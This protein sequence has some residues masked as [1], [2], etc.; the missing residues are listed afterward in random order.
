M[1]ASPLLLSSR[2]LVLLQTLQYFLFGLSLEWKQV[3]LRFLNAFLPLRAP[4]PSRVVQCCPV[5]TIELL[6]LLII[7]LHLLLVFQNLLGGEFEDVS[8]R[9]S[10]LTHRPKE[11]Y[12]SETVH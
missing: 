8:V 11:I 4:I 12:M 10:V 3:R 9:Q 6:L 5:K 7:L 2:T 1:Y